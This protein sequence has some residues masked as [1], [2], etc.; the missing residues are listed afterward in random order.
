MIIPL[1]FNQEVS[2]IPQ[3]CL[4]LSAQARI[5][6][7]KEQLNCVSYTIMLSVAYNILEK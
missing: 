1:G 3:S 2:L 4:N 5:K 6:F 7:T